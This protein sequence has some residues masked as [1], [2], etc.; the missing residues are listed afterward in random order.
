MF[1][2]VK[3]DKDGDRYK[4]YLS[5]RYR[6]KETK[7]VKSSDKYIMT[8][9]V[10]EIVNFSADKLKDHIEYNFINKGI[11]LGN[12]DLVIDKIKSIK[13]VVVKENNT[14]ENNLNN[15]VIKENNTTENN[16]E[17]VKAEIVEECLPN[18]KTTISFDVQRDYS[19]NIKESLS[20]NAMT[21]LFG[22]APKNRFEIEEKEFKKIHESAERIAEE[23][24]KILKDYKEI[25]KMNNQLKDLNSNIS[26]V[27]DIYI[28]CYDKMPK[29]EI[30][31]VG[32]RYIEGIYRTKDIILPQQGSKLYD[33]WEEL[34]LND[35]KAYINQDEGRFKEI[36]LYSECSFEF[37]KNDITGS[38]VKLIFSGNC[39]IE[40]SQSDVIDINFIDNT[41]FLNIEHLIDWI[42]NKPCRDYKVDIDSILQYK[43]QLYKYKCVER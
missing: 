25:E 26:I 9:Q 41:V 5:N 28:D 40:Y 7:K 30:W 12:I 17:L 31:L 24:E 33:C 10:N 3:K 14:T 8:L 2:S 39:E 23:I 43:E 18:Y 37:D 4:F 1:C 15:V 19:R 16:I 22:Q 38:L 20:F 27:Q 29:S 11:S 6:D 32:G 36:D 34:G 42:N 35:D 21:S 13:N